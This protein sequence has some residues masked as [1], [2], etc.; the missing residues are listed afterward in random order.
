MKSQA[1][2]IAQKLS[3]KFLAQG[4][5]GSA[6]AMKGSVVDQIVPVSA[7]VGSDL[8]ESVPESA[9]AGLEVQSVGY[10]VGVKDQ[11]VHIY[12]SRLSRRASQSVSSSEGQVVIEVNRIGKLL[13]RPEQ[14]SSA[15][16]QGNI[17][18]H[19][20]RIACG[21]SCAPSGESYAGT[22]G[23]LV[24]KSRAKEAALYIISNNHVL[25]ACNHTAVGMPILSPANIDASPTA[26]APGE[27]AR[28]SEICELRSG[29]PSL[30]QPC[31]EDL[32]IAKVTNSDAV[33]SWQGDEEHGFDTPC[34]IAPLK[35]GMRVKKF[36]RTTGLTSGTVEAKL[37]TP[38]PIPYKSRLFT[39]TVWFKDIWTVAG[40][41]GEPFALPGDSGSLV[42]SEDGT[43]SVGVVFAATTQGVYGLIMPM[44]HLATCFGKIELVGSHG[45]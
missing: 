39:A 4:S 42:A 21:S 26:R 35:S 30:V 45:V 36:G 13:V 12:V 44:N 18:I 8:E 41:D 15:S 37:N 9:F 5:Y 16:N 20:N 2:L 17:F 10:E 29:E 14:A 31:L 43:A 7:S 1:E 24:R 11:K 25:A 27:I 28:H 3:A 6:L 22:M 23:A 19:K 40:D 32:A 38:T 33:S 34:Q